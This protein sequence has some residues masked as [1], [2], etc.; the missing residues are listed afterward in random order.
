M[1]VGIALGD[2]IANEIITD[3]KQHNYAGVVSKFQL[4]R[5]R[6]IFKSSEKILL[7]TLKALEVKGLY[8]EAV[9]LM[10]V[11]LKTNY[12]KE[13]A[14]ILKAIKSGL[15]GKNESSKKQ[16]ALYFKIFWN[17][18]KVILSMDRRDI[19]T[20][21][22]LK[23]F[24]SFREILTFLEFRE[25][26]VDKFND[27]V[28]EH[29]KYLDSKKYFLSKRFFLEYLTWQ[30]KSVLTI[31]GED[32]S[33]ILTNRGVCIGGGMGYKNKFYHF[34]LDSCAVLAGGEIQSQNTIPIYQQS[35]ISARGIKSSLG[36]GKVVS[37]TGSE[38][39]F[40]V[41]VLFISQDLTDPPANSLGCGGG[42]S[43]EDPSSFSFL[44]SIYSNWAFDNWYFQ[45]EFGKFINK[46][47]ILWTLGLGYNF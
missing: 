45:T 27:R 4:N 24:E 5:K 2:D 37:E 29:L 39:G 32:H 47:D 10:A 7:I 17:I 26:K 43:V 22:Y 31:G 34:F 23:H 44:T 33:L 9:N 1:K 18:G 12:K 15:D 14:L 30:Q 8:E 42:C 16:S 38:I 11:Y 21:Q 20:E 41:P 6:E 13:H 35:D 28:L 25:E 36:V 46:N 19:K 40:K 3:Y